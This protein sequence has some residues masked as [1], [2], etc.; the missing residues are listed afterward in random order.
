MDGL[1]AEKKCVLAGAR[2]PGQSARQAQAR[3]EIRVWHAEECHHRGKPPNRP[4][5]TKYPTTMDT[6][7]DDKTADGRKNASLNFRGSFRHR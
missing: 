1:T 7:H 4:L 6:T 3:A 5:A 2:R